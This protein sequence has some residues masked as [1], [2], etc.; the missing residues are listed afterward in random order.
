MSLHGM[1]I[2]FCTQVNGIAMSW[3]GKTICLYRR[4]VLPFK[5]NTVGGKIENESIII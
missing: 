4:D 5:E 2:G 1:T 3:H